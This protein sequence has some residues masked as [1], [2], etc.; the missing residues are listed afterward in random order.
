MLKHTG[1]TIPSLRNHRRSAASACPAVS[2]SPHVA[3]QQVIFCKIFLLSPRSIALHL[4]LPSAPAR[5]KTGWCAA[6][7]IPHELPF[8]Q[9]C[10][11]VH[12]QEVIRNYAEV[13]PGQHSYSLGRKR[14]AHSEPPLI[15]HSPHPT[16]HAPL[17]RCVRLTSSL[18][19]PLYETQS[20]QI[21]FPGGIMQLRRCSLVAWKISQ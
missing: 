4:S 16:P 14:T 5:R 11:I 20:R 9:R 2:Q 12:P 21:H 10:P 8:P 13:V 7:Q 1:D 15:A 3:L 19:W 6:P 17:P 18:A